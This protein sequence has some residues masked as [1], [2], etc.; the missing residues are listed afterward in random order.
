MVRAVALLDLDAF[1]TQVERER[2][3]LDEDVPLA[4]QQW[5]SLIAVSYSARALGVS[6]FDKPE[7]ARAKGVQ[8]EHT[9][10]VNGKVS[11]ER[12]RRASTRVLACV[13]QAI[14]GETAAVIERA[15]IDE[16]YIDLTAAAAAL[17]QEKS[18]EELIE[19]GVAS[20][21]VVGDDRSLI[22]CNAGASSLLLLGACVLVQRVRRAVKE[23]LNYTMSGGIAHNKVL[24]KLACSRN[25]PNAQTCV[26]SSA[27]RELIDSVPLRKIPGLGGKLGAATTALVV[28]S[29]QSRSET[30]TVDENVTAADVRSLLGRDVLTRALGDAGKY[31]YDRCCG[32]D[33][34]AVKAT[35]KAKSFLA[36]KTQTLALATYDLVREWF[37]ILAKEILNRLDEE[38]NTNQRVAKTLV[39]HYSAQ[40][41]NHTRSFPMPTSSSALTAE[42][43]A[44]CALKQFRMLPGALPCRRLGLS[45]TNFAEFG[46]A[47]AGSLAQ[48][49]RPPSAPEAPSSS[50]PADALHRETMLCERH[51]SH[52]GEATTSTAVKPCGADDHKEADGGMPQ[53]A[54]DEE[55]HERASCRECGAVLADD[56]AMGLCDYHY[57]VH[58]QRKYERENKQ[59]AQPRAREQQDDTRC[60][61][62]PKRLRKKTE[63]E[64][65][66]ASS[67]NATQATVKSLFTSFAKH[68]DTEE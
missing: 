18:I 41:S 8:L 46:C 39:I 48:L 26:S 17:V 5:N 50:C 63:R 59:F 2:L 64:I 36:M 23:S 4:V 56:A 60:R 28:Q 31:V 44:D 66:K 9:E 25:K 67:S 16:C 38:R 21:H 11:L 13:T 14:G 3:G 54:R 47:N 49:W 40:G 24:A 35:Q 19:E 1:Y 27:A 51:E 53:E 33:N 30:S 22:D 37:V 7:G 57:A 58:L 42:K 55:F 12:Y 29:R 62:A 32:V 15:S 34:E 6:R 43:V 68:R 61:P 10:V 20:T 65:S 45:A 52:E